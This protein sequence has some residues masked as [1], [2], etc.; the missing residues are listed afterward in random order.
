MEEETKRCVHARTDRAYRGALLS[1][2]SMFRMEGREGGRRGRRRQRGG[3]RL[4]RLLAPPGS[5]LAAQVDDWGG[6]TA[7]QRPSKIPHQARRRLRYQHGAVK[8]PLVGSRA[9]ATTRGRLSLA[10]LRV[11]TTVSS[12]ISI[13]GHW[14]DSWRGSQLGPSSYCNDKGITFQPP[15]PG[16]TKHFTTDEHALS[17]DGAG[18][19]MAHACAAFAGREAPK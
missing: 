2:S 13:S 11:S 9:A 19:L 7:S 14:V 5:P 4:A 15:W 6:M 8:R 10:S 12:R 18:M 16:Q 3:G 17:L 1:T